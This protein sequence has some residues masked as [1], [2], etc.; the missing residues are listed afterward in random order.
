MWSLCEAAEQADDLVRWYAGAADSA[1]A[2]RGQVRNSRRGIRNADK[3]NQ[4]EW[5][6]VGWEHSQMNAAL[7][8]LYYIILSLF[9]LIKN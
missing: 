8:Y 2:A 4:G 6:D 3:V 1:V 7:R 5:Q 9:T